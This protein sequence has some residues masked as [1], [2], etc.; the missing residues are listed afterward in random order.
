MKVLLL[1]SRYFLCLALL[2]ISTP[3]FANACNGMITNQEL[4]SCSNA[5]Y[6]LADKRLNA[7]YSNLKLILSPDDFEKLKA[8]QQKWIRFKERHC[9]EIHDGISPGREA[10]IEKNMCL[11]AL[12][13]D[14]AN[15]LARL[16]GST[17]AGA[18]NTDD[19]AKVLAYI[20]SLGYEVDYITTKFST[21]YGNEKDWN[22]YK[23]SNCEFWSKLS[24][25]NYFL[26]SSRLNFYRSYY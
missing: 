17:S 3:I 8:V 9:Q 12:T 19:F 18:S 26:C 13:K 7:V 24:G 20:N 16:E 10:L 11:A 14:R 15:D 1:C 4:I 5:D 23:K 6:K 2:A 22:D 21:M 25:E